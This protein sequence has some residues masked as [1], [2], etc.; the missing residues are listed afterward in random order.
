MSEQNG[1]RLC[2][3]LVPLPALENTTHRIEFSFGIL[4]QKM[5][6]LGVHSTGCCDLVANLPIIAI[7]VPEN[8]P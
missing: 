4:V 1:S 3:L 8:G 2:G 5:V 6:V 7:V